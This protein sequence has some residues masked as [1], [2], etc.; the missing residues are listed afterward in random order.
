M[1][2]SFKREAQWRGERRAAALDEVHGKR[3]PR[4]LERKAQA[5]RR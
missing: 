1:E 5:S 4:R 3:R 2:W